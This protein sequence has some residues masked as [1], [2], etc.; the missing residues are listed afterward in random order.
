MRRLFEPS[1]FP[2]EPSSLSDARQPV[3][4]LVDHSWHRKQPHRAQHWPTLPPVQQ[5]FDRH[6]FLEG[7]DA[8]P[9]RFCLNLLRG[10]L[11]RLLH[12][13][14]LAL[15]VERGHQCVHLVLFLSCSLSISLMTVIFGFEVLIKGTLLRGHVVLRGI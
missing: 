13:H 12:L 5:A 8:S 7:L 9:I 3:Q 11:V 4:P 15:I 6:P 14:G 10:K 1:S 2:S